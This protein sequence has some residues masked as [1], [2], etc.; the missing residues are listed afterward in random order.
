MG[1]VRGPTTRF[2]TPTPTMAPQLACQP[3]RLAT[4]PA[5]ICMFR[6]FVTPIS[7]A[8]HGVS[9]RGGA[10]PPAAG[11]RAPTPCRCRPL[12]RRRSPS[13]VRLITTAPWPPHNDD[14]PSR[15]G[16]R[17]DSDQFRR[18]PFLHTPRCPRFLAVS[19]TK[20]AAAARSLGRPSG[21]LTRGERRPCGGG[22]R[23]NTGRRLSPAGTSLPPRSDRPLETDVRDCKASTAARGTSARNAQL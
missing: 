12:R 8:T 5:E 21:R 23:P 16:H 1:D 22:R 18:F 11:S 10:T 4:A 13:L 20:S 2:L 9:V 3:T 19:S 17:G 6:R 7:G 15:A 14:R